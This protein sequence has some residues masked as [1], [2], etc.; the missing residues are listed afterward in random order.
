M[1]PV[2]ML[3]GE[4]VEGGIGG[5]S[6]QCNDAAGPKVSRALSVVQTWAHVSRLVNKRVHTHTHTHT[7]IYRH[8]HRH[9]LPSASPKPSS[10]SRRLV[11]YSQCPP[12]GRR[13][14]IWGYLHLQCARARV[15]VIFTGFVLFCFVLFCFV[16]FCFVLF[17]PLDDGH[18]GR[19]AL[20]FPSGA[21]G[22]EPTCHCR[23]H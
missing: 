23:R 13:G 9:T 17:F 14:L 19:M 6:G 22:K 3:L 5:T 2:P 21:S 11:H 7:H 20:G 8:T 10:L 1:D 15:C 12:E 16:L 18:S 4:R